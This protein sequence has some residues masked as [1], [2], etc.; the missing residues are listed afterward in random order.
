MSSVLSNEEVDALMSALAQDSAST[1]EK[2]AREALSYDLT[3]QDR[4]VRGRLPGLDGILDRSARGFVRDLG[5]VLRQQVDV[6]PEPSALLKHSEFMAILPSPGK[7]AVLRMPPLRGHALLYLDF[8]LSARLIGALLGDSL[9]NN[10]GAVASSAPTPASE[11]IMR[12]LVAYFT[13]NLDRNWQPVQPVTTEI[14]RIEQEPLRA[15]LGTAADLVVASSFEIQLGEGT[16]GRMLFGIPFSSIEPLRKA[17]GDASVTLR[18]SRDAAQQSA[19]RRVV[20]ELPVDMRCILGE[21]TLT[22]RDLV[23]L[24]EGD[25]LR[26]ERGP[27]SLAVCLVEGQ[28]RL[29][30][31]IVVHEGNLAIAVGAA[32]QG[33]LEVDEASEIATG[34]ARATARGGGVVPEG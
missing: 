21:T 17:L 6:I 14:V 8:E 33:G 30:G 7:I 3:S 4:V 22:V 18:E 16:S 5:L 27:D 13:G 29:Q 34:S 25:I 28:P 11:R 24:H 20:R 10:D 12:R 23:R 26:L 32:G 19:M 9:H 31:R 2:H 15:A 1:G